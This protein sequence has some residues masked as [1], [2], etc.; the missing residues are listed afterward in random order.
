MNISLLVLGAMLASN[1]HSTFDCVDSITRPFTSYPEQ[2]PS[3]IAEFF[4]S[5][6][7]R[8]F[9]VESLSSDLWTLLFC[10][11]SF[12]HGLQLAS[13]FS[14]Y[15][16][17]AWRFHFELEEKAKLVAVAS[18]LWRVIVLLYTVVVKRV[19]PCS[20]VSVQNWT[21]PPFPCPVRE[22]S[23]VRDFGCSARTRDARDKFHKSGV[24]RLAPFALRGSLSF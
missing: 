23:A 13:P 3:G 7:V 6:D 12:H 14:M 19:A 4:C 20:R 5:T 17:L 18:L 21:R 10:L 22:I 2:E 9:F 11:H 24:I 8:G 16:H 15:E 1:F